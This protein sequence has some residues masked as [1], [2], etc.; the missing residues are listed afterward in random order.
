MGM[1]LI[2]AQT[3]SS[4]AASVT[5]SAI[6]QTYKSLRLV[7]SYRT[8][9]TSDTGDEFQV[10]P[11]GATT[12]L[13]DRFLIGTGSVAASGSGSVIH[14]GEGATNANTANTFGSSELTIPNYTGS[15]Y[16]PMSV[17]GVSENNATGAYQWLGAGLWSS[18]AA[19]TSLTL[20]PNTGPNFVANSSFYLYG[21]K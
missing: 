14:G 1:M 12:N 6:P 13:S 4:S 3:L 20:V 9:R 10:R 2:Q 19:I 8:D 11:N 16:K 18:S 17:D 5:F 15:T 21:I 7:A